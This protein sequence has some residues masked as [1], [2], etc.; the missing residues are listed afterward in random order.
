MS[1][2]AMT[3]PPRVSYAGGGLSPP[4]AVPAYALSSANGT[5]SDEEN[6]TQSHADRRP[7]A[8]P[9]QWDQAWCDDPI[10]Y[11]LL[12][13]MFYYAYMD[14]CWSV[15]CTFIS[16]SIDRDTCRATSY[17]CDCPNP[18]RVGPAG[19][20]NAW[21]SLIDQ[22]LRDQDERWWEYENSDSSLEEEWSE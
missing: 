6:S 21:I 1:S 5:R 12:Q 8:G 7:Y 17:K 3:V 4:R 13:L 14:Y 19:S 10:A 22:F 15:G 2:A 18:P 9:L 11:A 16:V 20:F